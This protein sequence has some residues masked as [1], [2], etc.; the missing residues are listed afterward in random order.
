MLQIVVTFSLVWLD[1]VCIMLMSAWHGDSYAI[2][3]LMIRR[4]PRSTLDRSSAASDVYKR[5][6]I[7]QQ[8]GKQTKSGNMIVS[9]GGVHN[10]FLLD[11]IK[12]YS[13]ASIVVPDV[14][15]INFKEALI[16]AFLGV[17]RKR[18]EVNCLSS[19]TGSS[20]DNCGGIIWEPWFNFLS[21]K[22]STRIFECSFW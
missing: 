22:K 21:I 19:V 13:K 12:F 9:G 14:Q 4:P 11:R 3:F 6:H 2:F 15:I 10:S 18:K 16:F 7:A 20:R 5:Q 8:I 17:L 1:V